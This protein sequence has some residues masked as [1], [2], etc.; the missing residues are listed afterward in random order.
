MLSTSFLLAPRTHNPSL[1]Q[2]LVQEQRIVSFI[3]TMG[4]LIWHEYA[5]FVSITATI[6]GI[7][8]AFWALLYRK[9]FWDFVTGTVRDPGGVQP[10]ASVAVF[11]TLIVKAPVIPIFEMLLGLFILGL[12]WPLPLMKK[13]PIYRSLIVRILLLLGQ[14]SLGILFYQGTNAAIWSLIAIGCYTRAVAKGET[15]TEVKANRG[16]E[17]Q[18]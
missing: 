13:L 5:R 8:A 12:E 11:I 2:P 18:A 16:R 7:W 6:Y 9:F 10:S 4:K 1:E 17:G 15:M 14:V 3:V